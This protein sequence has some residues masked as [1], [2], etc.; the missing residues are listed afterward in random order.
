MKTQLVVVL[1]GKLVAAG[2]TNESAQQ[3]SEAH[4]GSTIETWTRAQIRADF[5]KRFPNWID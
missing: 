2:C 4:P 5:D 3:I 1:N